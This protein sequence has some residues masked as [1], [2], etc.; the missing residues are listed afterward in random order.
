[1]RV[2]GFLPSE[3]KPAV[4]FEYNEIFMSTH[5]TINDV[6]TTLSFVGK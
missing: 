1:M 5:L 4:V 6:D 2:L 3:E